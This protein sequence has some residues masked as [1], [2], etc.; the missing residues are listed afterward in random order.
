MWF[1]EDQFVFCKKVKE[2]GSKNKV[3]LAKKQ[4]IYIKEKTMKNEFIT[5]IQTLRAHARQHID[6]GATTSGYKANP[7]VVIHH[8]AKTPA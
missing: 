4:L 3:T 5:D 7:D 1:Q 8:G 6:E 2:R